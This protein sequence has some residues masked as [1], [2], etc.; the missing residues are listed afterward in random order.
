MNTGQAKTK[1]QVA[2][3]ALNFAA[4]NKGLLNAISSPSKISS[5]K[6]KKKNREKKIVAN[7][8]FVDSILN[9]QVG[10]IELTVSGNNYTPNIVLLN[11]EKTTIRDSFVRY[12][13]HIIP[14]MRAALSNPLLGIRF[15]STIINFN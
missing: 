12:M 2:H 11:Q 14:Q 10:T 9:N 4:A 5:S 1:T 8:K 6:R 7:T 3:E 15:I 13:T